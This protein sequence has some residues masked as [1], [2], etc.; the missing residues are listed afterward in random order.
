VVPFAFH[1]DNGN[2][3]GGRRT[4]TLVPPL[5]YFHRD[6]EIDESSMTVVGPVISRSNPKRNIFDVVPFFF[7]I[8]GKPETGGVE[9]SHTTIFPFVH[10]GHSPDET[11]F[12]TPL[13][14]RRTTPTVDT[15]I[16]PLFTHATTRKG[17]TSLTMVGPIVPLFY[18]NVDDD[19]G[20]HALGIFPFYYGSD[21]PTQDV[22]LTP[23]YGSFVSPGVSRTHWVFPTLTVSQSTEGWETDF[24]PIFY[25]GRSG[26]S[27]HTVAAP[28]FWDFASPKG[29]TTI[30]FPLYWRFADQTDDSITQIAGNT[31]YLQRRVAGGLDWQFHFLPLFSYGENPG[32]Y[33]WNVLFGLAG[34]DR[35]GDATKIRALWL[36]FQLSGGAPAGRVEASDGHGAIG[37]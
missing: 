27:S 25:V 37:W 14:L 23:L 16:T 13:Y 29:R 32:G 19:V 35:S 2:T 7:H 21:S 3:D 8:Q 30:G 20:S 33:W 11:L 24:H 5:L 10:W 34:Y 1:G 22:F 4:Y 28:V 9:E 12:V 26:E 31:L 17:A 6:R 15:M 36:P 18:R